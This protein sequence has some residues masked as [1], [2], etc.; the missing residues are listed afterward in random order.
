MKHTSYSWSEEY[1]G[2]ITAKPQKRTKEDKLRGA[3][4]FALLDN[5]H[6]QHLVEPARSAFVAGAEFVFNYLAK[7]KKLKT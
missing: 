6:Y 4:A 7:N 1:A 2:I 3:V 5:K